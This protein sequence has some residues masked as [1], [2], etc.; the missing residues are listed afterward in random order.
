MGEHWDMGAELASA[1]TGRGTS[2]LPSETAIAFIDYAIERG[3][4][5][6]SMEAFECDDQH[7]YLD[8]RYS[9]KGLTA[10]E[11]TTDRSRIS[12]ISR[13]RVSSA[14]AAPNPYRF[15]LWAAPLNI[16]ET[17]NPSPR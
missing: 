15:K 6:Q 12:E 3:A 7:E 11:Q 8:L 17:G 14:L 1:A 16:P 4:W 2:Y 5:I 13:D 9:I 10:E